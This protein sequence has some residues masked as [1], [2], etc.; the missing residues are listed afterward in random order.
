M[1]TFKLEKMKDS[2]K[3]SHALA[4]ANIRKELK[5]KY[6]NCKFKVT[7]ESYTGGSSVNV[8]WIDGVVDDVIDTIISKYKYGSFDGMIDMYEY[9]K[10]HDSSYGDV[11]YAFTKRLY[12]KE[13]IKRGMEDLGI[14]AEISVSDY[15]NSAHMVT[16]DMDEQDRLYN[17][18]RY[19][20]MYKEELKKVQGVGDSKG[21]ETIF[22]NG[23]V[24]DFKHT[25]SGEILKVFKLADTLT[26]EAFKSFSIF[27][28]QSK[29]A[30]Y[31]RYAHGF[32]MQGV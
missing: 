23:I 28:K 7:T 27:M 25:R 10:N 19:K 5:A 32:V 8:A 11:K 9:D 29:D 14:E 24:E 13:A 2:K 4:G 21:N 17:H 20:S 3:S 31:S 26:K 15:D 16:D 18:L 1:K 12:S 6:P 30:Y 22:E